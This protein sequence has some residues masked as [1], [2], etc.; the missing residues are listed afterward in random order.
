MRIQLCLRSVCRIGKFI[1]EANFGRLLRL[2]SALYCYC[3]VDFLMA[4]LLVTQASLWIPTY[5]HSASFS[6]VT[7]LLACTLKPCLVM[8]EHF[9]WVYIC[10]LCVCMVLVRP[11]VWS[12]GTGLWALWM[13]MWILWTKTKS[14]V[15]AANVLNL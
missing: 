10:S 15:R 14:S 3:F 13:G 12:L 7:G 8:C 9:A 11:W 2:L 1:V 4:R 5:G 6:Q